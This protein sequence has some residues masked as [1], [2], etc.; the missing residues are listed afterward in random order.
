MCETVSASAPAGAR[1]ARGVRNLRANAYVARMPAAPM[2][3][4]AASTPV[5]PANHPPTAI[6]A[7]SILAP[8]GWMTSPARFHA[9]E[10]SAR[11]LALAAA[12]STAPFAGISVEG[13]STSHMPESVRNP[14][15]RTTRRYSA[16]MAMFTTVHRAVPA[17]AT[18]PATAL[19]A[20]SRARGASGARGRHARATRMA[21]SGS[22][23]HQ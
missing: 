1:A 21:A 23:V 13:W 7:G 11:K 2:T 10:A 18:M 14:G 3:T 15:S 8:W 17:T 16:A 22:T 4:L 12:A 6:V 20:A 5:S 19:A 9:S